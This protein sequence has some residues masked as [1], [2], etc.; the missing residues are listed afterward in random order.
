MKISSASFLLALLSLTTGCQSLASGWGKKP[1][2]NQPPPVAAAALTPVEEIQRLPATDSVRQASHVAFQ[3]PDEIA[4]ASPSDLPPPPPA[5]TQPAVPSLAIPSEELNTPAAEAEAIIG[6]SL[7]LGDLEDIALMHNPS[8][9]EASSLVAAARGRWVQAGLPPNVHLGYEGQQ[10]GSNGQAEQ[11][12]LSINQEF[13]RGG[14]LKLS[15][16]VVA[17][18]IQRAE[19]IYE[20]QR[21]RVLTDVRLGYYE[22]LLAQRRMELTQQIVDIAQKSVD[23]TGALF[24]AQEVSKIDQMRA[25]I[26]LQTSSVMHKNAR[27]QLDAAWVNLAAVLGQPNMEPHSL[28]GEL[29]MEPAEIDPQMTLQRLI[30]ASPEMSAAWASVERARWAVQREQAE[31]VPNFDVGGVIQHDASTNGMNGILTFSAPIPVLN[32]NQG[33]IRRAHAE[34]TA[35]LRNA[36]RVELDLQSRLATVFQRYAAARNQVVDYSKKDGVLDNSQL[37]LDLIQKG[38]AAGELSYLDL[39]AAQRTYAQTHLAYIEA[40]GMQWAATSELEGMLLKGS[41]ESSVADR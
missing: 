11:N 21:Q 26:E 38:Y 41:L 20:A 27:T 22:V 14:K 8:L 17:Q 37:T 34:L 6:P 36:A 18:E 2:A 4:P 16:N 24:E 25:R 40:L 13:I 30:A 12:G 1:E 32:R 9:G 19:Q 23:T 10:L 15:Q 7:S 33:A 39:I 3:Q 28:L 35:S 5:A 29:S 31:P